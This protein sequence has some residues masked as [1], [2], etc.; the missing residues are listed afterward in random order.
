MWSCYQHYKCRLVSA[1]GKPPL[2]AQQEL[3]AS[4]P[5]PLETQATR[6]TKTSKRDHAESQQ[7]HILR[8]GTVWGSQHLGVH[9]WGRRGTTH[10]CLL[11]DQPC[12]LT[13]LLPADGSTLWAVGQDWVIQEVLP[14]HVCG[15]VITPLESS[16]SAL[17][18]SAV[19]NDHRLG[20][21]NNKDFS[22]FWKLGS[23]RSM[24][25]QFLFLFLSL[26]CKQSC[27]HVPTCWRAEKVLSSFKDTNL[28]TRDLP[29]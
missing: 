25:R 8:E 29:S 28:I 1:P 22:Q 9:S 4:N 10:V 19:T 18:R 24:C 13:Q 23:L 20:G 15:W 3:P 16:P 2:Q 21:L 27:T 6:G 7:H 5:Q 14:L 26:V 17:A 12:S 11:K